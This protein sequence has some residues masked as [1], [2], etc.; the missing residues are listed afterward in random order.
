MADTTP[1]RQD[2]MADTTPDRQ[3]KTADTTPDRQ[4]KMADTTPDHIHTLDFTLG[5]RP[6]ASRL[7]LSPAP[8]PTPP[9]TTVAL[10]VGRSRPPARRSISVGRRSPS[11]SCVS[12]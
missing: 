7:T 2:K 9:L 6:P 12:Q 11:I 3:D 4:D 8:Q 1:D 5:Q 10:T